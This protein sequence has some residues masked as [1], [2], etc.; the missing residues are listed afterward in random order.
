[1]PDV[2][3]A[4]L[5]DGVPSRSVNRRTLLVGAAG[6]LA[7]A[8]LRSPARAAGYAASVPARSGP[9][10]DPVLSRRL[11]R[12]LLDAS[13]DPSTHFPGAILRVSSPT[14]GRWTGFVGFGRLNPAEPMRPADR[15]RAGSIV[16]TF[17]AVTVLQLAERGRLSLDDRLTE[18]LPASVVGRFA[19][20]RDITVRMLLSHRSG[21]PEWDTPAIDDYIAHHPAKV[22]KV[23]EFLDLAAAQPPVFAPGTS[24]R[25]SNTDYNLLGLIIEHATDHSWRREVTRRVITPLNLPR[26]YLPAP[27]HRSLSG[28]HAHGYGEVDGRTVDLTRVD[29]SIAGAAGGGALVTTVRDLGRFLDALLEGRLFRSRETLQEMLDFR[30]APDVG[31]QVGYGLGIERRVAPGGVDLIGHLGGAAGYAAYVGRLR[32][33]GVTM[34]YALNWQGDPSPLHFRAINAL[35]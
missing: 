26:T 23:S 34:S 32:P 20:A 35:A 24:Y 33:R 13:R 10:F 17:V 21:I 27:G 19:N 14:L 1:M 29:P 9:R 25:Y 12:V 31:G 15:F 8:G 30:P 28:A 22:W 7:A 6:A 16:K 2:D 11:R 3:P 4:P 5:A 18:V